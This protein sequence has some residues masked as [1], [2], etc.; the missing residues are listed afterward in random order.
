MEWISEMYEWNRINEWNGMN[1]YMKCNGCVNGKKWM[2]Q[3]NGMNEMSW[4]Y[5]IN[6][7]MNRMSRNNWRERIWSLCTWICES[8]QR[9]EYQN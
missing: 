4:M 5:I 9:K 2:N 8:W 3:W 7:W 1:E 6:E